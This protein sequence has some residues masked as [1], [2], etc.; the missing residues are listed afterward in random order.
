MVA[1]LGVQQCVAAE[2]RHPCRKRLPSSFHTGSWHPRITIMRIAF[3]LDDTLIPGRIPFDVEP[4]PR[5]WLRRRL[6]AE[7]L[8][9][10][11]AALF[12]DL[13]RL[14]HEVWIYT[15]SF[16]GSFATKL[17]FRGYGTHVGKVINGDIH[18]KWM[19][20]LGEAYKMCTKYPP[21]FQIDLL[22]DDCEGVLAESIRYNFEMIRIA[23]EDPCWSNVVHERIGIAN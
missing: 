9:L 13:W 18:R 1:A 7:P 4:L 11:T 6:C 21:A 12:N 17:F 5:N 19:T 15:T 22:V 23:P 8:R 16:R 20:N 10:G 3:D 2:L 14:G